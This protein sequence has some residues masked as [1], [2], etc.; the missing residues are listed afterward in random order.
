MH[1]ETNPWLLY[2]QMEEAAFQPIFYDL[3]TRESLFVFEKGGLMAGMCKLMP[4]KFRNNHIIYLG[5]VAIDPDHKGKGWGREMLAEAL[6]LAKERGY[7][8]VELTVAT[9]NARAIALYE[10]MGFVNEGRLRNYTY[11][12]SE[13]RYIDEYVMGLLFT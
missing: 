1:P 3:I 4:Q 8:R 9:V 13:G 10:S 2:E 6:D 5:G 7:T 12:A 11:L